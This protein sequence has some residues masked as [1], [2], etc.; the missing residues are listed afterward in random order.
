VPSPSDSSYFDREQSLIKHRILDKYL[1][2][3]ARIVG[4]GFDGI[5]YVDG[6][7]GPWNVQ[8]AD[9]SD[10]SFA[11]A[12]AQLRKARET[13]KQIHKKHLAIK[14]VFLEKEREPF[15]QLEKY[16]ASQEDVEVVTLNRDFEQAVPELVERVK[17]SGPRYFPFIFIDPR[18][19]KGFS[20]SLIAPLIQIQ[21]CEVLINFMTGFILRF[22]E[23]ERTGIEA[24][25]KRLF[26]DDSFKAGLAGLEGQ[27]REDA[28]VFAYADKIAKVGGFAH[29]PV[30]IVPHP[31]ND[32]THFHLV[33]ATRSIRGLEV[34]KDAERHALNLVGELRA[35][36]KRRKRESRSG[37][38]E[39]FAGSDVPE[40]G[41]TDELENHYSD[42]A[43]K[44]VHQLIHSSREVSY[45]AV[46][47]TGMRFPMVQL[48]SL[49]Q[50]ISEIADVTNLP[51]NEKVPKLGAG[52]RVKLRDA[53]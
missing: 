50:Y 31:T 38:A 13:V 15:T 27:A 22:I 37:Q 18:G 40:P 11:I 9:F 52:H 25:F 46:Y 39:F 24:S 30:T 28:L 45:D 1:E 43:R 19:W 6:F 20:M 5:I 12:L 47:A 44:A 21:P 4:K 42:M 7:S 16:A 10:S 8:S 14:C 51:R 26:G 33:Y 17:R 41:F 53:L 36:A 48:P 49:R 32:R 35:D 2:R 23:D 29:V 34:F 3:F